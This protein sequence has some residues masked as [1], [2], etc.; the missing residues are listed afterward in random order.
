MGP[1]FFPQGRSVNE[2]STRACAQKQGCVTFAAPMQKLSPRMQLIY[3]HLIPGEPV[4]DLCC[5]H[6]YMGLNAYASGLFPEVYFVDQVEHIVQRLEQQFQQNY[7]SLSSS[8]KAHFLPLPGESV[9]TEIRGTLVIAGVGAHTIFKIVQALH[10]RGVLRASKMILV[11]QKDEEKLLT[12]LLAREN[13][14]YQVCNEHYTALERGRIRK[15][16][17]FQSNI[18]SLKP[19]LTRP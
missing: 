15:L 11:P 10:G 9:Q 14:G 19:G 4:W 7:L 3:D 17:I 2:D 16:L 13:F 12:L 1:S 8:V 18:E 5:D 6:G